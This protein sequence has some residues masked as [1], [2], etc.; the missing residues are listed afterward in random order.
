M[1]QKPVKAK[2]KSIAPTKPANRNQAGFTK[3]PRSELPSRKV[4][5]RSLMIRDVHVFL[6]GIE[7]T[8]Y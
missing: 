1:G 6:L 8:N 7:R 3:Y 2:I 4:P 5:A